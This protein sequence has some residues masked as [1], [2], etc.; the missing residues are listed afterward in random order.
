MRLITVLLWGISAPLWA[1]EELSPWM[2]LREDG[3]G[4]HFGWSVCAGDFDGDGVRDIAVGAPFDSAA[5]YRSGAVYIFF[6]PDFSGPPAIIPGLHPRDQMGISCDNAGDFNGDGYDDLLVGANVVEDIG[7]AYIFFGGPDLDSLPDVI[8]FGENPVDNFGYSCAGLGDLN[9]DGYDDVAVGALYNDELG[10][11]TGKVY[12]YLGGETPDSIP[13][14]VLVGLSEDDD[15]GVDLDGRFDFDGDGIP[16]LLVGAVQAGYPFTQPGEAYVF[17]GAM[18]NLGATVPE[19]RFHG[20]D[21]FNFFGGTV[22]ALGDF[23]GDG[24]DDVIVGAY[25]YDDPA[26]PSDTSVGRAYIYF[27]RESTSA[28]WEIP[29]LIFTGRRNRDYF[30]GTVGAVGDIN[31]DGF[32]DAAV[33]ASWDSIT[34]TNS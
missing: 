19:F 26:D 30:G 12:I 31:G 15:F 16:D 2:I 20:E 17:T 10:D 34:D 3:V 6:G 25:N 5:G 28:P 7:A 13:D 18:L 29:D 8:F 14:I 22:A 33:A 24:K 11:R 23:N 9:G 32:A 4:S 1:A 27:G 21:V